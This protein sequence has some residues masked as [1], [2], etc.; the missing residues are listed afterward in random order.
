MIEDVYVQ[1]LIIVGDPG[2]G[3]TSLLL[4]YV[5]D[6]FE[7]EYLSTIG[8]DFYMQTLN[9]DKNEVKL[10]IWDTGGQEK[11]ANIRPGYYIGAAGALIV[12]DATN[13]SSFNNL[14]K[15]MMEVQKY[16]PNIPMVIV[17]NKVDLERKIEKDD[18]KAFIETYNLPVFETSAKDNV[19]IDTMFRY[20]CRLLL[21]L[22]VEPT[23]PDLFKTLTVDE[24]KN[25]YERC[26]SYSVKCIQEKNY[27]R[28][29]GALE[30][31]FIYSNEIKFQ[32]G[33]DWVQETIV[34]LSKLISEDALKEKQ[35][36]QKTGTLQVDGLT[37]QLEKPDVA[38]YKPAKTHQKVPP[39]VLSILDSIRDKLVFG[40]SLQNAITQLQNAQKGIKQLYKPHPV[41][42]DIENTIIE[43]GKAKDNF[44]TINPEFRNKLFTKIYE[45][46][47]RLLKE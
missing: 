38:D 33:I 32:K 19:N 42:I 3:K 12:F 30:K 34:F 43:L 18:V 47:N 21:G 17:Q 5:E 13:S 8:V 2:V 4:R 46:K 7:E 22:K 36:K 40:I 27:M 14:E 6:R 15:W 24:V 39:I 1:K 41:L 9:I 37:P 29:L 28:A 45:W 31:A 11:F 20:I 23:K 44:T 35:Q 25:N 16:R 10:Q 26:A